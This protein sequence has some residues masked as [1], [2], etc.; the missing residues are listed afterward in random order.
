MAHSQFWKE[1]LF[2]IPYALVGDPVFTKS[3]YGLVI[4]SPSRS[5]AGY[6]AAR[7]PQLVTPGERYEVSGYWDGVVSVSFSD[8]IGQRIR[9]GGLIITPYL[10][11]SRDIVVPGWARGLELECNLPLGSASAHFDNM[12]ILRQE[13]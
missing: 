1:R 13:E 5:S 7:L 11:S 6:W 9:Q 3:N 10:T 8:E 12:S 4:E 2:W